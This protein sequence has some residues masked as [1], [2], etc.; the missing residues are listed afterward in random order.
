MRRVLWPTWGAMRRALVAGGG[1]IAFHGGFVAIAVLVAML[2]RAPLPAPPAPLADP[3]D[4]WSGV[5][6]AI[7][8]E[9]LVDVNVDALGGQDG[10]T[11]AADPAAPPSPPAAPPPPPRTAI[12][13]APA[14][15]PVAEKPALPDD[16]AGIEPPPRPRAKKPKPVEVDP[17]ASSSAVDPEASNE[18]PA[19]PAA[20]ASPRTAKRK[21]GGDAA[22][23]SGDGAKSGP[24]GAEGP[25]AVRSLGRAFTRAIPAACQADPGWGKLPVGEAGAIEVAI[26]IDETGHITGYKPLASDPPTQLLALVKRTIALLDAGTFALKGSVGAGVEVLRI[27]AGVSDLDAAEAGGVAALSFGE[28]KAAFT[29]E[30]GRH[31]E[32]TLRVVKVETPAAP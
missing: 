18:K 17:E 14:P 28:G 31:V 4:V 13:A 11:G 12:A 21:A 22:G 3:V 27:Q 20:P 29:Q 23:G 19:P 24:F 9:R 32:V 7:G 1:S 15:K 5:T 6:A 8:G 2:K 16:P 25:S 26:T 30:G 10:P